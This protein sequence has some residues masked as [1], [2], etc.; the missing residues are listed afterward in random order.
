MA[1]LDVYIYIHTHKICLAITE[2]WFA[3]EEK[4]NKEDGK[5]FKSANTNNDSM[6][7]LWYYN[8][9]ITKSFC[10]LC[11]WRKKKN[12]LSTLSSY[13]QLEGTAL[14]TFS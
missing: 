10:V 13:A 12:H 4:Q 9:L 5:V 14:K 1:N 6:G 7:I 3:H 2:E 8:Y 11:F